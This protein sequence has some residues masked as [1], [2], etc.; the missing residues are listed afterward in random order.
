MSEP[1]PRPGEAVA[2]G[3]PAA[4]PGPRR[5]EFTP[6]RDIEHVA[7]AGQQGDNGVGRVAAESEVPAAAAATTPP[8]AGAMEP[9]AASTPGEV[10][11]PAPVPASPAPAGPA[12]E[13]AIDLKWLVTPDQ[14][15]DMIRGARGQTRAAAAPP[16][17]GGGQTRATDAPGTRPPVERRAT[18]A[19]VRMAAGPAAPESGG[20]KGE[21]RRLDRFRA[22][23]EQGSA[24]A[25]KPAT[26]H[27]AFPMRSLAI[28]AV[29]AVVAFI[30][31]LAGEFAK[32]GR[33]GRVGLAT[34]ANAEAQSVTQT[35]GRPAPTAL[36][37]TANPATPVAVATRPAP[38]AHPASET[39]AP[40]PAPVRPTA[41]AP[42]PAVATAQAVAPPAAPVPPPAPTTGVV[43]GVVRDAAGGTVAGARVTVRGT[44]LSAVSDGSGAFEIREV[45]AGQVALQATAD[46]YVAGSAPAQAAAGGTVAAD[47]SL[48]RVQRV[49]A[50]CD[51]DREIAAGGWTPID[52]VAATATLG[53]TLGA[54]QGLPI[55]SIT[56]ST[57]GP[58]TRVRIAQLTSACERI[59]LTETR[60]GANVRGGTGPA[61][62]TALRIMPASEAYPYATG[63]AS[64]GN[65]LV[66]VKTSLAADAL[67]PLLGRLNE[68]SEGQ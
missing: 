61:M 42:R 54:I 39:R 3:A 44:A 27:Q 33:N 16:T 38:A 20:A 12:G 11:G 58:R 36:Q 67:R 45:P 19:G 7:G 34:D 65:I 46:G 22:G 9:A 8:A 50:N 26:P 25:A 40:K 4:R 63:S 66:T 31:Y 55:E 59:V 6:R 62:V 18:T 60:A 30:G 5:G 52:R 15:L 21:P 24:D 14:S 56:A 41:P 37:P 48:I 43:H 28:A 68:I 64:F 53:G 23:G 17:P 1:V 2:T 49:T 10:P 57:S 51:A 47:I 35:G 13:A 32:G 29:I